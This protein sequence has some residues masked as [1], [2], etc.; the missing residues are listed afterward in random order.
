MKKFFYCLLA[1]LICFLPITANADEKNFSITDLNIHCDIN[2]N[3][4]LLITQELIYDF[5]GDFNGIYVNLT[6]SPN[7]QYEIEDVS[8]KNGAI[9]S[10]LSKNSNSSNNT[11]QIIK[12]D[13]KTQ[14]KIFCKSSNEKKSFLLKYKIKNACKKYE[15]YSELYW[16]FFNV[17]DNKTIDNA[18]LTVSLLNDIFDLN[19]LKYT[20]YVNGDFFAENDSKTVKVSGKDLSQKLGIKLQFQKEFLTTPISTE[21]EDTGKAEDL[22][23]NSSSKK[24]DSNDAIGIGMLLLVIC[25]LI[26]YYL[27]STEKN[28]KIFNEK[29]KNYRDSFSFFDK[30]MLT[31]PP[32]DLSPALVSLL[33]NNNLDGSSIVPATL[34]YL[35]K[36]GY[37]S[38][39]IDENASD[40]L[41]KTIFIRNMDMPKPDYLHINTIIEWF[42][43]YEVEGKF[44]FN[45]LKKI[46]SS[47]KSYS[48]FRTK[49][50]CF[51]NDVK[52][53][54]SKLNFYTKI[55]NK[56]VLCNESYNEKLK[57]IAF[58]RFLLSKDTT[59]STQ[60]I[61][62][63]YEIIYRTVLDADLNI[64][65]KDKSEVLNEP[66]DSYDQL[67]FYSYY[68]NMDIFYDIHEDA[69]R[70]SNFNDSDTSNFSGFSDSSDFSGGGGSDSG[71]F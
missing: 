37:Y 66:Y 42:S 48:L 62:F 7:T 40:E 46:M 39:S 1:L 67:L 22:N 18:S 32:S 45:K 56:E 8:V 61:Q 20:L 30:D 71:A 69:N 26:G 6:D 58:R 43:L 11:Y 9:F 5:K 3:G 12:L 47:S 54:A 29:L 28:K 36:K 60:N 35:V 59:S 70:N 17:T 14:V 57:W 53:D 51:I 13:N 64:D 25:S 41:F 68:T 52:L 27:Y 63:N 19:K 50:L 33:Y 16:N 24:E 10:S 44:D 49:N 38:I 23:T 2:N 15:N 55:H 34:F 65:T 21:T 4:D 31:T